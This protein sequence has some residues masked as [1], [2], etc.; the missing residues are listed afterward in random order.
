MKFTFL[1]LFRMPSTKK[2]YFFDNVRVD[3][4]EVYLGI[5]DLVDFEEFDLFLKSLVPVD[6]FHTEILLYDLFA[7]G[8]VPE[9]SQEALGVLEAVVE[10]LEELFPFEGSL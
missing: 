6:D 3:V 8:F 4:H 7:E 9:L 10:D 1:K 5:R 2:S